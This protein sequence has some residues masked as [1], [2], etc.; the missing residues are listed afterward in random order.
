MIKSKT[1]A[2]ME[3]WIG[4]LIIIIV[5][6][7]FVFV[8]F[9]QASPKLGGEQA[10][11]LARLGLGYV[12]PEKLAIGN[13]G[14]PAEDVCFNGVFDIPLQDDKVGA[15]CAVKDTCSTAWRAVN[16]KASGAAVAIREHGVYAALGRKLCK[17]SAAGEDYCYDVSK[18]KNEYGAIGVA[19]GKDFSCGVFGKIKVTGSR[20]VCKKVLWRT[21]CRREAYG[22]ELADDEHAKTFCTRNVDGQLALTTKEFNYALGD[23]H[24][25]VLTDKLYVI[26]QESPTKARLQ[27]YDLPK[28]GKKE[29]GGETIEKFGDKIPRASSNEKYL[30]Y[31]MPNTG[32][33]K[34]IMAEG[35]TPET[36]AKGSGINPGQILKDDFAY[37]AQESGSWNVYVLSLAGTGESQINSAPF[38]FEP[39]EIIQSSRYVCFKEGGSMGQ[40]DCINKNDKSKSIIK[41]T[42]SNLAPGAAA[43]DS[44]NLIVKFGRE[45]FNINLDKVAATPA[46][47]LS[48]AGLTTKNDALKCKR[49]A[50]LIGDLHSLDRALEPGEGPVLSGPSLTVG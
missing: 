42:G 35:E 13:V 41:I 10:G 49:E 20:E 40:Y 46:K 5:V 32:K 18:K 25:A 44:S 3:Q 17:Y 1:G 37:A 50:F 43:V 12:T 26:Q 2:A 8:F 45:L 4:G 6:L 16:T 29:S 31:T 47:T 7:A 11:A 15:T 23:D 27:S 14:N 30:C 33:V 34:C 24:V 39:I 21:E 48:T 36:F 9:W 22:G 28:K 38:S 19:A